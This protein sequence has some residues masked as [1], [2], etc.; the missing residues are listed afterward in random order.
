[1]NICDYLNPVLAH[2]IVILVPLLSILV[3]IRLIQRQ[4]LFTWRDVVALSL[5]W[6]VSDFRLEL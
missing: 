1:M 5:K 6:S 4:P 3:V 2:N